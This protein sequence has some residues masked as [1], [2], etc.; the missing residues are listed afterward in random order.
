[1]K[2]SE[3]RAKVKYDDESRDNSAIYSARGSN[4]LNEKILTFLIFLSS[5]SL[6][7]AGGNSLQKKKKT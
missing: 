2:E 3:I 6:S 4:N 7:A 5:I 1:M